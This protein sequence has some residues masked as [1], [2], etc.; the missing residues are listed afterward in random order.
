MP[1]S[2]S[3]VGIAFWARVSG[4]GPFRK[5]ASCWMHEVVVR[6]VMSLYEKSDNVLAIML[7]TIE[8]GR[9]ERIDGV[10]S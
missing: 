4:S 1:L 3:T 8:R 6:V 5:D 2:I 9:Q 10:F 7:S